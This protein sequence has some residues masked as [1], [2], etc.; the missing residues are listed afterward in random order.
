[1]N[2]DELIF[3]AIRGSTS[4]RPADLVAIMYHVDSRMKAMMLHGEL[5]G[6]LERLIKS[7]HIRELSGHRFY[8]V[9]DGTGP[10]TFSGLS[11]EEHKR[12]EDAYRKWFQKKYGEL[13]KTDAT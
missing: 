2:F 5:V 9:T 8:E 1:M 3:E 4:D 7:G 10:G 13:R 11:F 12:A 6:G